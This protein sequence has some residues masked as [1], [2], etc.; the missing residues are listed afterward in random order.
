MILLIVTIY[1][2]LLKNIVLDPTFARPIEPLRLVV[3][4]IKRGRPKNFTG[5]ALEYDD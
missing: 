2:L 1:W 4:N 5:K 3:R